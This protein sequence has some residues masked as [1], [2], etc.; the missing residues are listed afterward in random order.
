VRYVKARKQIVWIAVVSILMNTFAPAISHALSA[1]Q[2][3][4]WLDVC[5]S[6]GVAAS[7]TA[8][9]RQ[10]DAPA[11]PPAVTLAHCPYCAPQGASFAAP[12]PVTSQVITDVTHHRRVESAAAAVPMLFAWRGPQSRA[13]PVS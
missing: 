4:P 3:A 5:A 12:P 2:V 6:G 13:P 10:G 8:G 7:T 11:T 1:G 9:R